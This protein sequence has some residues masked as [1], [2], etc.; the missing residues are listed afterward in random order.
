MQSL[1]LLFLAKVKDDGDFKRV[2]QH[3]ECIQRG[4]F[5]QWPFQSMKG[6]ALA[7]GFVDTTGDT[8]TP[9]GKVHFGPH[10]LVDFMP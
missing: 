9:E 7:L 3:M 6:I 2:D 8:N 4:W 1:S 10:R 5:S